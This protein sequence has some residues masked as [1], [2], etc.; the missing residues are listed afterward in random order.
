[1]D[2]TRHKKIKKN[3]TKKQTK[4]YYKTGKKWV[5]AIESAQKILAKTGS[6]KAAKENLKKQALLNARK[7]FSDIGKF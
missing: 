1:M 6:F 7:L 5:S 4:K 2:T 3:R